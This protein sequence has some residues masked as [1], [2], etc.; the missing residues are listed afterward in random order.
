VLGRVITWLATGLDDLPRAPGSARYE[1]LP[2]EQALG[3]LLSSRARNRLITLD[4]RYGGNRRFDSLDEE[5]LFARL[6][7]CEPGGGWPWLIHGHTHYPMLLPHNAAGRSVRYANS[8]CAVLDRAFTALEWD[9]SSPEDPL[10]LVVWTD[11]RS[12]KPERI[13]LTPDGPRLRAG[14]V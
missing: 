14:G 1:G 2:D 9:G 4:P 12:T 13:R 11:R 7:E 5:R 10:H 8:G 3:K 6:H